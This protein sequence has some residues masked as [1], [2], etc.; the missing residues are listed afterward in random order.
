MEYNKIISNEAY[1]EFMNLR[2]RFNNILISREEQKR[3]R[4]KKYYQNTTKEKVRHCT[5]CN[6]SIKNN[7]FSNHQNSKK[8][9]NNLE[10]IINLV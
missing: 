6:I 5:C 3:Q 1:N 7:S 9:L 4:E 2:E 8:H 10:K